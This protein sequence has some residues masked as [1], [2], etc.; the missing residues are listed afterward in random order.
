MRRV[1]TLTKREVS[2]FLLN[3]VSVRAAV[4]RVNIDLVKE[5]RKQGCI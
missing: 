5:K 3:M 4:L 2:T 1:N